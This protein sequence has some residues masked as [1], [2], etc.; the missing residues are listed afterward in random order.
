[1][2]D[3]PSDAQARLLLEELKQRDRKQMR[4][5]RLLAIVRNG[6]RQILPC[7]C[8][9]LALGGA[10]LLFHGVISVSTDHVF[11]LLVAVCAWLL[12]VDIDTRTV[13]K[14]LDAL[15]DLLKEEGLLQDRPADAEQRRQ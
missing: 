4:R 7:S 12:A 2:S 11:L 9:A 10:I 13:S 8:F 3:V 14:R 15:V 1:M 6:S 5:G